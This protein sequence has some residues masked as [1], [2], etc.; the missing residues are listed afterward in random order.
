[1][2]VKIVK[3]QLIEKLFFVYLLFLFLIMENDYDF[4]KIL[5]G[6]NLMNQL[7]Y[8]CVDMLRMLNLY[9]R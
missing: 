7:G 9:E 5:V 2:Y 8:Q 6:M 4:K 1:M 3:Y